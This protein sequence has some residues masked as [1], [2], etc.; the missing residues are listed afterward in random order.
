MAVGFGGVG[1]AGHRLPGT[2]YVGWVE[3]WIWVPFVTLITLYLFLLFPDGRLPSPRWRPVGWLGGAIAAIAAAGSAVTLGS[4]RPN[5]PGLRNPFGSAPAAVPLGQAG[6]SRRPGF[7]R[8][9]G[10]PDADAR[11]LRVLLR[12]I[13][14]I[15]WVIFDQ[16]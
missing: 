12:P 9:S 13:I 6:A 16:S 1:A 15:M 14:G 3:E 11:V 8:S 10:Q 2:G 7:Q 4:D 5:L